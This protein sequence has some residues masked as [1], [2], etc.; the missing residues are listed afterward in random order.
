MKQLLPSDPAQMKAEF[1]VHSRQ[2]S[3]NPT[4]V[5]G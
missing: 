3:D 5:L 2:Y 4:E 1:K